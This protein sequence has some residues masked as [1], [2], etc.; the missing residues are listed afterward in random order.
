[1]T[2]IM[3]PVVAYLITVILLN[4][5]AAAFFYALKRN[6][7]PGY[8][9][10]PSQFYWYFLIVAASYVAAALLPVV[11]QP[12]S[13]LVGNSLVIMAYYV[14]LAGLALRLGRTRQLSRISICALSNIILY[15]SFEIL[16]RWVVTWNTGGLFSRTFTLLN[17]M[18]LVVV[19]YR[20][21]IRNP[22]NPL[23]GERVMRVSLIIH[24]M[25]ASMTIALALLYVDIFI[26]MTFIMGILLLN[27]LLM[28]GSLLMMQLSDQIEINYSLSIE[29]PLTGLHNRRYFYQRLSEEVDRHRRHKRPM[30]LIIADLDFFKSINDT[31]GHQKGD[32]ILCHFAQLLTDEK[33]SSDI[34]ARFGGEEFIIFLPET[35]EGDA[36]DWAER[37]LSRTRQITVNEGNRLTVSLGVATASGVIPDAV[38]SLMKRADDA[39]FQAKQLGRDQFAVAPVQIGPSEEASQ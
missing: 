39:L 21:V 9:E 6:A 14:L 29:D 13:T 16:T 4:S 31:Y 17:L 38:E 35:A 36:C 37:I 11:S 1:M 30:S 19:S 15:L 24:L 7:H 8:S 10:F 27:T 20:Y 25:L 34:V 12:L 28:S 5:A 18:V 2:E 22:D 23:I 32:E 26:Y 33:R 3:L